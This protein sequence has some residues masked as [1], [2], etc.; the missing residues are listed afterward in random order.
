[1]IGHS[2]SGQ[3]SRRAANVERGVGQPSIVYLKRRVYTDNRWDIP[4]KR[5]L[6]PS[7]GSDSTTSGSDIP[8]GYANR[9][10]ED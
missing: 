4:R 1:M 10:P 9:P 8:E 6:F 7:D 2:H 5:A 3:N